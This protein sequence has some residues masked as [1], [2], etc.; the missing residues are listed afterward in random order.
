[1]SFRIIT[2]FGVMALAKLVLSRNWV[3]TPI[4]NLG[5]IAVGQTLKM[6]RYGPRLQYE[7]QMEPPSPAGEL[8]R[9]GLQEMQAP[10]LG[11]Y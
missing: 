3:Y 10:L 1:M 8:T 2:L 11:C 4:L 7:L 6:G 9:K 5:E